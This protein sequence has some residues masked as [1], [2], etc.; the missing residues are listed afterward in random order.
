MTKKMKMVIVATVSF[1]S[2]VIIFTFLFINLLQNNFIDNN[3]V[4]SSGIAKAPGTFG[5]LVFGDMISV[6]VMLV[7]MSGLIY[8]IAK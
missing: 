7:F 5:G 8:F 2:M 1:V 3:E 4:M 6:L